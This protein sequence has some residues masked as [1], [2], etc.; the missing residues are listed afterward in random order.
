MQID[1]DLWLVGERDT[2]NAINHSCA[3]NCELRGQVVVVARR[4][5]AA[6]EELTIDYATRNGSDD[7]E[8]ECNCR[9]AECRGK[10]TGHDWMLPELQHRYGDA[11]SPYLRR[12]AAALVDSGASRRAFAY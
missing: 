4:P 12:R 1:D 6:G 2:L 10:V 3:P 9:T 11:F 8:F 5:I 7:D